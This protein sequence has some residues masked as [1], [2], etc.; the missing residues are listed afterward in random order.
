MQDA[1]GNPLSSV[2]VKQ[3][4]IPGEGVVPVFSSARDQEI[5]VFPNFDILHVGQ[6]Q[7]ALQ[8]SLE[9]PLV[10]DPDIVNDAF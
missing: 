7:D 4:E 3:R 9:L 10:G 6:S 2:H 1:K 8:L 5:L